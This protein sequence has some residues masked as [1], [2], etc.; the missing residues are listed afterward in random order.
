MSFDETLI[1]VHGRRGCDGKWKLHLLYKYFWMDALSRQRLLLVRSGGKVMKTLFFSCGGC[2]ECG[3]RRSYSLDRIHVHDSYFL[4]PFSHC[5]LPYR[6]KVNFIE[7]L[8]WKMFVPLFV[9][10][11]YWELVRLQ[12]G[13]GEEAYFWW[14][15][16][17]Y[18]FLLIFDELLNKKQ[19]TDEWNLNIT[20][21]MVK[22]II[23]NLWSNVDLTVDPMCD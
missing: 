3:T 14:L 6:F 4:F 2:W 13:F 10:W 17:I 8:L 16:K 20:L 9:E 7:K 18:I 5:L 11:E 1:S 21:E 12:Y 15:L 23:S 22:R 19:N